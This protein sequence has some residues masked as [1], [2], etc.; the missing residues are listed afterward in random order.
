MRA[1]VVKICG[2]T[3]A[4]DAEAAAAAGA[5]WIG[6]NFWSRSRRRVTVEQAQEVA[7]AIPREILRVGVFV[8]APLAVVRATALAVGLD[9]IQLH[10][11]EDAR[12]M[13][14]LGLPTLRALRVAGRESLRTLDELVGDTILLDAPSASYGGSGEVFDWALAREVAARGKRV[15]LAGGLTAENVAQAIREARPHGVDVATGVESAPGVKDAELM[16]RFVHAARG[17]GA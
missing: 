10:G 17:Q 15:I 14:A 2:V 12:Y 8:N 1:L 7:R 13:A 3:R 5:D 16:R 9:L 6:L 11:D 4:A